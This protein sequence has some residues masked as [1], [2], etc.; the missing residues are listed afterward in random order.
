MTLQYVASIKSP[1]FSLIVE[2]PK[3]KTLRDSR[4]NV[5]SP[6]KSI[7]LIP[8]GVSLQLSPQ[9]L[10]PLVIVAAN[11]V[12]SLNFHELGLIGIVSEI[13]YLELTIRN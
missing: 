5:A 4:P 10:I 8:F 3:V 1:K 11:Y 12:D 6:I 13:K 2:V 7:W 9:K